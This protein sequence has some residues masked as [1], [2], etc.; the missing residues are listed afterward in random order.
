[1]TLFEID[2]LIYNSIDPE[3]GEID[4]EVLSKLEMERDAKITNICLFIK[5]L[6]AD[7]KAY[8]EQKKDFARKQEVAENKIKSLKNY[9]SS[10]LN[11]CSWD[12]DEQKRCAV[13][14]RKSTSV[15]LDLDKF[16]KF[17]GKKAYLS[18]KDPEP[19]KTAIKDALKAGKKIPG[20]A[21]V[22]KQN[23]QIK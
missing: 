6:T 14:Y 3:T 11:G 23:I 8:E 12:G 22:D 16:M 19:N 2:A 5:N 18:F 7:A 9:L 17:R 13:S 1:M 15:E 20:C 4:A 21:L 10:Y